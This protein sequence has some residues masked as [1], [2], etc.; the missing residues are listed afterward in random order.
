[1]AVSGVL[2]LFWLGQETKIPMPEE[3]TDE[4]EEED[5]EED[6]DDKD[7]DD[8]DEDETNDKQE[9]PESE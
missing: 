3:R 2:M 5:E 8:K 4:N 7:E 6:E 9:T 1:M